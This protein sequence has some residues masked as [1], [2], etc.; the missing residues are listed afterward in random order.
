MSELAVREDEA[1]D[2]F[3]LGKMLKESGFFPDAAT[4]AKAIVKVLAG[5]EMGLGPVASMTGLY[6]QAGRVSPSANLVATLVRKSGRYDYRVLRLDN[7]ACE[8]EFQALTNGQVQVLGTFSFSS[9]DAKTA[10]LDKGKNSHS[11][12]HYPRNMLFARA[13][14]NGAKFY[15]PEILGGDVVTRDEID[16]DELPGAE[17]VVIEDAAVAEAEE[18]VDPPA[19]EDAPSRDISMEEAEANVTEAFGG[20][21]EKIEERRTDAG[22]D[23]IEGALERAFPD[24]EGMRRSFLKAQLRGFKVKELSELKAEQR[25]QLLTTIEQVVAGRTKAAV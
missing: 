23:E 10:E 19:P 18:A 14:T 15:C 3:Q 1:M 6:I 16:E 24:A 20:E 8:I 13:I 25:A 4:E 17:P 7:E 12:K 9:Q 21:V 5:R 22:V 2:I 11:W